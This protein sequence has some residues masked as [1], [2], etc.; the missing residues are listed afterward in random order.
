[1]AMNEAAPPVAHLVA[2]IL[3]RQDRAW[4]TGT[5]LSIDQ[6]LDE[7]P[8]IAGETGSILDL[9]HNEVFLRKELGQKP[10]L[11][12]YQ[13]RFPNLSDSL[14]IQWEVDQWLFSESAR[15]GIAR[16]IGS[17]IRVH[18]IGRY[19][20]KTLLGQGGIGVV[21]KTWDPSLK[22][23][24]AVKLLRSGRHATP[25]ELTRFRTEAE[26]IAR[27]RHAH[28]VQVFDVGDVEG[29]PFIA[30]ELCAGGT[31]AERLQQ[32][33]LPPR[34]AA[35]LIRQI[36]EGIAAAHQ[37]HV[38]H[39]DLKPANVFLQRSA[40]A[41][42]A[43]P[44]NSTAT[45]AKVS[46]FGLAK[47]LDS[48]RAETRTGMLLGT[49]AYMSPEQAFGRPDSVGPSTDIFALGAILY[50]CLTGRSPFQSPT[51][52]ATLELIRLHDPIPIRRLQSCVPIDLETIASQCLQK[53]PAKRYG[54]MNAL[55]EDLSLFLDGKPIQ[56]RPVGRM[57]HLRR[58]CVRNP[59]VA[60]LLGAVFGLFIVLA[61]VL[62]VGN[63]RLNQA[64]HKATDAEREARLREAE[65]LV[66]EAHGIR[67]SRRNGQRFA[68]LAALKKAA[69][70]GRE[71]GMPPEW[72]DRLRDEAIAAL[73][74]P[75]MHVTRTWAGWPEGSESIAIS[76]DWKVY[77]RANKQ[78]TSVR[79]FADDAEIA[80]VPGSGELRLSA[81]ASYLVQLDAGHARI[82]SL[83]SA[84]PREVALIAD[85]RM[86][87]LR[88]RGGERLLFTNHTKGELGVYDL[89]TGR[90]QAKH[91]PVSTAERNIAA[92][93]DPH[94]SLPIVAISSYTGNSV[95]L[96]NFK[97]GTTICLYDPPWQEPCCR[98][99][100][101]SSGKYLIVSNADRGSS[102]ILEFD[103]QMGSV[104]DVRAIELFG[105]GEPR[106]AFFPTGNRILGCGWDGL[107]EIWDFHT[108]QFLFR[109]PVPIAGSW[110]AFF[111][112]SPT[113]DRVAFSRSIDSAEIGVWSVAEGQEYHR[114]VPSQGKHIVSGDLAVHPGG[115]LIAQPYMDG[116]RLFDLDTGAE[117]AFI[118]TTIPKD[119]SQMTSLCF[120]SRGDLYTTSF[121]GVFR[122]PM[123]S[124]PQHASRIRFGPP[125]SLPFH[126]GF[127]WISASAEGDVIAQAQADRYDMAPN[128][129]GWIL[130]SNS[131]TPRRVLPDRATRVSAVSPDGKWVSFDEV[132][133]DCSTGDRVF[134]APAKQSFRRF[135][136]DGSL[137][138]GYKRAFATGTWE[139]T[140]E[141]PGLLHDCSPDNTVGISL[142]E[143]GI[144]QLVEI[145]TGRALARLEDPDQQTT[146]VE[147]SPDGTKLVA[148]AID[149]LRV[150]DLR[151]I[152]MELDKLGLD[153]NAPPYPPEPQPNGT[154]EPI[155]VEIVG[156]K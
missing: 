136:R 68:A 95:I 87:V 54:S 11:Q 69:T 143:G 19:E 82:W 13:Q 44:L 5:R 126:A 141:I 30:M 100:W 40:T 7:N 135:S 36:A 70:I 145:S 35:T 110:P 138:L 31:L 134:S 34:E 17:E 104:K 49:P 33:P 85:V 109:T 129:G 123:S 89:A 50:E 37:M 154:Q 146:M 90:Q 113:G 115:R 91:Q 122:W 98:A 79:R 58:W 64:L 21:Y 47:L 26:A 14:R 92:T 108:G 61:A 78:T 45:V 15:D 105:I 41:A 88:E 16:S 112:L 3:D 96:R 28:V 150:W 152:R 2:E 65:A 124:D 77:A 12:E 80:D 48:D 8:S 25:Q 148:R 29:E 51:T 1:M 43:D 153:W 42:D 9:I 22:R 46:D 71:L 32:G 39:R 97:T 144:F 103:A 106:M 67:Y 75:D 86:L 63:W 4:R 59:M 127:Q 101:H 76:A 128:K 120:D 102:R 60:G 83:E 107:V 57:E 151:R 24:A 147:F 116:V 38:V 132:L 137:L 74:L 72:F 27:I 114:I 56:A 6:I 111:S 55:R 94:P 99:F 156:E 10:E 125:I 149:G 118:R 23:M 93:V 117:V 119:K 53:E 52:A 130:H 155:A 139:P 140:P 121:E 142:L 20:V 84:T 133:F 66:G 62:G 131:P 73:T 81:D 18:R